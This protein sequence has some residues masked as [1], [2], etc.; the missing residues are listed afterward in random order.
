VAG[1]DSWQRL[2]L[3]WDRKVNSIIFLRF[4]ARLLVSEVDSI[5]TVELQVIEI[6][7][8]ANLDRGNEMASAVH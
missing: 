3:G 8:V 4:V 2:Y 6:K 1:A 7:Q 5:P